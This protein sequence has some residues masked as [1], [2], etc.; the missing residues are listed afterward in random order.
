MGTKPSSLSLTSVPSLRGFLMKL[1][2]TSLADCWPPEKALASCFTLK[3]KKIRIIKSF[4]LHLPVVEDDCLPGLCQSFVEEQVVV[5]APRFEVVFIIISSGGLQ[6]PDP[7]LPSLAQWDKQGADI[8]I[9]LG[10][11]YIEGSLY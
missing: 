9:K 1:T 4:L 11:F 3:K 2:M 8:I 7:C 5:H 6:S 10:Y